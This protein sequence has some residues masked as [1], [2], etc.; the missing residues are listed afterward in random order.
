MG[1]FHSALAGPR[2]NQPMANAY[3][4]GIDAEAVARH[5]L[6]N[7]GFTVLA[8]RLRTA[9]GEIDIVA[10]TPDLLSI[11]EVKARPTLADA[12]FALGRRQQARL[13]AAAEIMLAEHP[14]WIRRGMRFDLIVVDGVG[15]ARRITDAF[16][17]E[18]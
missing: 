14:E 7:D 12:A 4:R 13:L 10:A 5:A 18:N 1:G 11:V 9:A 3:R 2:H 6:E 15:R 16:R 17:L 8:Q